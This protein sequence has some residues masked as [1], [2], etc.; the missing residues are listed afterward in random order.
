MT[1]QSFEPDLGT[2]DPSGAATELF[3]LRLKDGQHWLPRSWFQ[4]AQWGP[5]A[6]VLAGLWV[7]QHKWMHTEF[8]KGKAYKRSYMCLFLS[9][10]VHYIAGRAP[11]YF[12]VGVQAGSRGRYLL[13][14]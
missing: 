13:L 3:F 12:C 1:F 5:P 10:V 2:S 7:Q 11:L 9:P 8:Q 4:Y 14:S 6:L